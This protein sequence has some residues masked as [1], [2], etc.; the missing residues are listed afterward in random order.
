MYRILIISIAIF[1]GWASP[2]SAGLFSST[3]QV[4]A[5]FAGELFVGEA[6]GNLDGSGTINIHSSTKPGDTC[7][8]Q[9][10]S[11]AEL[12]GKGSLQCSDNVTATI[13]FERLTIFRGHGTGISSRG[14]MSFTY[15]LDA[16]GSKPY[17][18]LPVGTALR[19]DGKVLALVEVKKPVPVKGSI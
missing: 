2:A 7:V 15:G 16:Q 5:I 19:L 12:G 13:K 10:T 14:T 8:G 18:T 6:E 9:F 17:L 3:G 1:G 4:I 11:S